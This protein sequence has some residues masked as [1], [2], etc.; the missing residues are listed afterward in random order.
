MSQAQRNGRV[1]ND[2]DAADDDIQIVYE[3]QQDP[4]GCRQQ[5]Q[6]QQQPKT[7]LSNQAQSKNRQHESHSQNES[8]PIDLDESG[9]G[10]IGMRVRTPKVDRNRSQL[11][12]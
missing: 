11:I 7:P 12:G 10:I 8:P 4:T 9:T 3:S 1:G 6:Q 2:E 5:Q